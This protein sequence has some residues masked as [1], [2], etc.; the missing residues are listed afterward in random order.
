MPLQARKRNT[1]SGGNARRFSVNE[2]LRAAYRR[3]TRD[4]D[5]R[6]ALNIFIP[7]PVDESACRYPRPRKLD[8]KPEKIPTILITP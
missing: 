8:A 7:E 1:L 5:I 6:R 2:V 3:F 4:K